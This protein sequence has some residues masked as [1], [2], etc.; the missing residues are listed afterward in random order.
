MNN[1]REKLL[2][3][4]EDLKPNDSIFCKDEPEIRFLKYQ[5][6]SMPEDDKTLLLLY[7]ELGSY[8]LVGELLNVSHT[9]VYNSIKKIRNEYFC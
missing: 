9:L 2:E 3:L 6:D 7:A 5:L 8:R 4:K 1:I